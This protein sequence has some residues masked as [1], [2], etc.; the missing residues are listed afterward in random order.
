MSETGSALRAT[1][2][3]LLADLEALEELE[4][5]KRGLQPDDPQLVNTARKVES[6][7]RRLLGQSVRQRELTAV[8]N[9]LAQSGHPDAPQGSIEDSP[10]EI[11]QILADWRDAER[12][13]RDADQG[14]ADARAAAADVERLREEY[15]AAHDSARR[16][17]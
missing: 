2:D 14:S 3:A 4:R 12:R 5:Q 15:R 11:H 1:S 16:K 17:R 6:I 8:A 9:D 13:A 10:R 7:A